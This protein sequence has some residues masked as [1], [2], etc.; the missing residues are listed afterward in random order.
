MN[1]IISTMAV[2]ILLT[3]GGV[4]DLFRAIAPVL[5]QHPI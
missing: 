5:G 4:I 3:G 2:A 1:R